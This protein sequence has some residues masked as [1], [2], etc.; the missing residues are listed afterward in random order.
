M[1]TETPY[2]LASRMKTAG[3]TD[4]EIVA[5]LKQQ[6]VDDESISVVLN[7]VSGRAA[8]ARFASESGYIDRISSADDSARDA[9]YANHDAGSRGAVPGWVWFILIYGV[10]NAILYATT[11]IFLIPI[12]RR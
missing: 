5:A 1:Q 12:P 10:G 9:E 6:G 7:S 4:T 2:A 8:A 11:G 3:Q